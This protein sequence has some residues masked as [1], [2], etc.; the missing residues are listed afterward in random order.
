MSSGQFH[1][2]AYTQFLPAR[3]FCR[4]TYFLPTVLCPT[5]PVPS[6]RSYNQLLRSLPCAN[7]IIINLQAAHR[8]F[9]KLAQGFNVL[10][11]AFMPADSKVQKDTVDFT[12]FLLFWDLRS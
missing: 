10:Q 2:H 1:Q 8:T 11:A 6:T 7:N 4:S 5:L 3:M 9:V 12:I